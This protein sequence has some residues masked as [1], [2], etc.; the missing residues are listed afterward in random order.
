MNVYF[1]EYLICAYTNTNT[2]INITPSI[3]VFVIEPISHAKYCYKH[4]KVII[5]FSLHNKPRHNMIELV[6]NKD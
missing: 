2:S 5:S 6:F 1:E 3:R 4:L